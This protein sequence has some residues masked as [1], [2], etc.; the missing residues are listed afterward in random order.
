MTLFRT[1]APKRGAFDYMLRDL[2]PSFHMQRLADVMPPT[3]R[4]PPRPPKVHIEIEITHRPPAKPQH[5]GWPALLFFMLVALAFLLLAARG[6]AEE[7][8][9]YYKQGGTTYFRSDQ[10]THGTSYR[11]GTTTYT[12]TWTA[13]G[14]FRRCT[15]YKQGSTVYESCY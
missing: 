10:G 9:S 8:W 2:P 5:G 14:G 1:K 11:L 13:D 12:D 6:H 4:E 7:A 15:A 3:P